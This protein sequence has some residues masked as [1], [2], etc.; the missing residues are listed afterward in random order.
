MRGEEAEER[1]GRQRERERGRQREREGERRR[2][3][4]RERERTEMTARRETER[5]RNERR[6]KMFESTPRNNTCG[7]DFEGKG[8][9]IRESIKWLLVET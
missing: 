7:F 5:V 8:L 9:V 1:A 2:E 3:K 6:K 4:E